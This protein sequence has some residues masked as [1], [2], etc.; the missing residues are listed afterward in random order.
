MCAGCKLDIELAPAIITNLQKD[1][2]PPPSLSLAMAAIKDAHWSAIFILN[3]PCGILELDKPLREWAVD[4]I[5][6]RHQRVCPALFGG[7]QPMDHQSAFHLKLVTPEDNLAPS[8][9]SNSLGTFKS[10]SEFPVWENT[11]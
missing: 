2:W 1:G 5:Q 8:S 7:H 3:R 6:L 11:R 4:P 10:N 9:W